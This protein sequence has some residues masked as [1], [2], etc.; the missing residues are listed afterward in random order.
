M[1]NVV[2]H[3]QELNIFV[4]IK[5]PQGD[6]VRPIKSTLAQNTRRMVTRLKV[7]VFKSNVW[8]VS[9]KCEPDLVEEALAFANWKKA[10][11]EKYQPWFK[12]ILGLLHIFLRTETLWDINGSSS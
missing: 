4:P 11:E 5:L 1:P 7:G 3:S 12:I 10:M 6:V 2:E 9:H 8:I